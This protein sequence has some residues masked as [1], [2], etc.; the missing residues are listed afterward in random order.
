METDG[1]QRDEK[2]FAG[3]DVGSMAAKCIILN[4]SEILS[5]LIIPTDANPEKAAETVFK[6]A[7]GKK[8]LRRDRVSRILGTGYGRVSSSIFHANV[9]EL[10]GHARGVR[11]LNS[12]AEGLIDIGGQDSKAVKLNPNGSI[13]DFA[14]N[15]RC[16]AGTGR[17]L[18]AMARALK[19][20]MSQIGE[21]GMRAT[22]PCAI[23]STC[24]V[25]AE[26][27]VI[28]LLAA[29]S[30]RSDIAAGLLES[31]AR[32]VG[33]LARRIGLGKNIAFV[34]GGAKND[35]LRKTL[36]RFL[37]ASFLPVP[38]DPQLTGALGAALIAREQFE[39][40]NQ[41]NSRSKN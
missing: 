9:T 5:S 41:D 12:Q 38:G 4:K 40:M 35:G 23:N 14:M 2:L 30:H 27:E 1:S 7:L 16:A 32:R 26:S 31:I 3:V 10:S 37:G 8:N 39:A 21:A 17:F 29:G 25:F 24:V 34:G 36:E 20:D 6:S 33:T 18:E 28:S 11:F 15:D 22:R 19:I 13:L